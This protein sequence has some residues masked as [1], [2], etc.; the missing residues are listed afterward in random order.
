MNVF[1]EDF[2]HF[3]REV[4]ETSW[5]HTAWIKTGTLSRVQIESVESKDS[6]M[7][8]LSAPDF[9]LS[10]FFSFLPRTPKGLYALPV[11]HKK[12]YS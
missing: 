12:C 2:T 7:G 6:E 10:D 3:W 8:L 11:Q 1:A 5:E 4:P 9:V